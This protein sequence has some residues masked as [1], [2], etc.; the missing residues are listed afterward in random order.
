L[1]LLH[2]DLLTSLSWLEHGFGTR[3]FAPDPETLASLRQVHS[4]A[5]LVAESAG[6]QGEGDALVTNHAGVAVAV[7]TADCL[8]ILLA[9]P[10]HHVVAAVHAGWRGTAAGIVGKTLERMRVEFGTEPGQVIAAIGPGIGVCCYEVGPEVAREFG[11]GEF[12]IDRRVHVDLAG[13]NRRR[14]IAAGV[15]PESIDDLRLCTRCRA[16]LFH[17]WRRD[18]AEA[19]RMVSFLRMH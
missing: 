17:S 8:P 4:A 10:A 7:R 5:V 3:D 1:E 11:R 13:E 19:G 2:S 18:G 6:C 15:A 9:D 16:D 12:E 14:L